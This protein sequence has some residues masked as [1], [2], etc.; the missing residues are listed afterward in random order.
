MKLVNTV[1]PKVVLLFRCPE[2]CHCFGYTVDCKTTRLL[3]GD[4][5]TLNMP[6][7]TRMLD[8]S[9]NPNVYQRLNL[10]DA[11]T[12]YF[13]H[14]NISSCEIRNLSANTFS[15]MSNLLVLDISYNR[16]QTVASKTFDSQ[17]RLKILK[18]DG[19]MDI[20]SFETEAF[21][22][23]KSMKM[24]SVTYQ[25][26]GTISRGAFL[27]LS[28]EVLDLSF[29]TINM[30]E[31]NAFENLFVKRVYV[32]ESNI[33]S[34]SQDMFRGLEG[35][36]TIVSIA[37]KFCCIKP[38]YLAEKDCYPQQDEF[39]SCSDLMR[40][41]ILRSLIWIIG[42]FSL[43]GNA[44]S[45]L[46]RITY[47]KARLKFGYGIFVSNLALSDFIMGVYLIIIA[48][49][50]VALRDIYIFNDES[51]RMSAGC[52][53]AGVLAALSSESSIIFMIL[54]TIDRLLV[55]KYPF[56]Q[57]KITQSKANYFS[58]IAWGLGLVIAVIPLI[59]TPYFKGEFYSK[60]GVCLAL[61]LTRDRPAGWMYSI[62]I[63][64][65][66]NSITFLLIALGQWWIYSEISASKKSIAGKVA[67]R[68]N[69][70]RIA[71]NLLLVV[72]TD[73]LCWFPIGILGRYC[74]A[75]GYKTFI[76]AQLS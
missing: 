15:F 22:G 16:I 73:F 31:D 38:T 41:E 34:F 11:T 5:G 72:T 8:V 75:R 44:F 39:S 17:L 30:I 58:L 13:I 10:H 69:D 3:S 4:N 76:Y 60:S 2:G 1:F 70:L 65:G 54:I 46:Y 56:G 40:N 29:N 68:S 18:L 63:F 35:V 32:N 26:I 47:D 55:I 52:Q 45:I 20:I 27:A 74:Q 62:S 21:A 57:I 19:N 23:L 14:L 50:D 66:F 67:R 24:F 42:L 61:P 59:I 53:F 48:G 28:L 36:E 33:L 37:Y 51:W 25:Q 6:Q 49:A 7:T 71:R 12:R 43:L 9:G 64:I